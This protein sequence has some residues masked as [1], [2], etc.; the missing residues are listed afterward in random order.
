MNYINNVSNDAYNNNGKTMNNIIQTLTTGEKFYLAMILVVKGER[1][2][3][4]MTDEGLE[5]AQEMWRKHCGKFA[6]KRYTEFHAYFVGLKEWGLTNN[7][8][9][10]P[11]TRQ[12]LKHEQVTWLRDLHLA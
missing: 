8:N 7:T 4:P 1:H 9:I 10:F 11:L 2:F 5:A 12:D 3:F 6:I